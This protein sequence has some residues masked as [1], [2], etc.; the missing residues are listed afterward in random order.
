MGAVYGF[1]CYGTYCLT[2]HSIMKEWSWSLSISDMIWGIFL[3]SMTS[4]FAYF[5]SNKEKIN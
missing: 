2:N 1:A 3:S 4:G 5:I